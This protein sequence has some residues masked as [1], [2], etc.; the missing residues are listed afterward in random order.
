MNIVRPIACLEDG[1]EDKTIVAQ[2]GSGLAMVT[3]EVDGTISTGRVVA[4]HLGTMKL[5]HSGKL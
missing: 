5:G 1:G 4:E 2:L 3:D